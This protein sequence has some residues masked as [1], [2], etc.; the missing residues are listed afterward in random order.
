MF[1]IKTIGIDLKHDEKFMITRPDGTAEYIFLCFRSSAKVLINGKWKYVKPN[2]C[3]LY[4]PGYPQYYGSDNVTFCNDWVRFSSYDG[5]YI[6]SLDIPLNTCFIQLETSEFRQQLIMLEKELIRSDCF[7]EESID[8]Q[9]RQLLV[10]LA[11]QIHS[12]NSV[13]SINYALAESLR[14]LRMEIYNSIESPWTI[15]SMAEKLHLSKSY[16][17]WTYKKLFGVSP[18][19]DLINRRLE[20]AKYYLQ[21]TELSVQKIADMLGYGSQ[22]HFIRQFKKNIGITPKKYSISKRVY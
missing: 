7:Y 20:K 16:F 13:T 18:N 8:L 4:S 19:K 10:G 5:S 15:E 21:N 11:R 14:D 22:Y 12:N 2:T 17:Q 3:I 1:F 6:N 9:I